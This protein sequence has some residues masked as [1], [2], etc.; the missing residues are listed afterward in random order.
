MQFDR[1]HIQ[2]LW[3]EFARP[4]FPDGPNTN[5][6]ALL[7]FIPE[8]AEYW[9]APHSKMIR[10]FAMAASIV[11]GKPV[12]IGVHDKLTDLSGGKRGDFH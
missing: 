2:H 11:S 4:W 6:I 9:D 1:T 10:L 5:Y 3:T 8:T 7:K 12:G